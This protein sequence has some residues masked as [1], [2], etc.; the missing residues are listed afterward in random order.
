MT[1]G[2]VG[3]IR[4]FGKHHVLCLHPF[5]HRGALHAQALLQTAQRAGSSF[6]SV[7]W[8]V[9][10]GAKLVSLSK[11]VDAGRWPYSRHAATGLEPDFGPCV[12]V[13][14][15]RRHQSVAPQGDEGLLLGCIEAGANEVAVGHG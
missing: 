14:L 4:A 12:S 15:Q 9:D 13:R 7:R 8:T 10:V 6:E 1:Q 2:E 3:A 11:D 5:A